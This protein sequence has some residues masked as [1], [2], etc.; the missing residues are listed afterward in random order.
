MTDIAERLTEI[1]AEHLDCGRAKV[2]PDARLDD[3]GADSLD[4]VEI[5]IAV[6]EEFGCEVLDQQVEAVVT[7]ADAIKVI[8]EATKS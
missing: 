3:L 1:I 5:M 2:V 7:V 4:K 6:E 8:E